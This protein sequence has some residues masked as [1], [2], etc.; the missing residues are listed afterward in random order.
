M[1]LYGDPAYPLQVHLQAP[2]RISVPNQDM[3]DFNKSMSAV[4]IAVEWLF[5]DIASTYKFI[6]YMKNLKVALSSAG[7]MYIVAAILRNALTCL[8]GNSTSSF[9]DLRNSI[10]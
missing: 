8:Y 7:K 3:E 1:C 6:D 4:P 10:Q 5:G 2:F 9:F